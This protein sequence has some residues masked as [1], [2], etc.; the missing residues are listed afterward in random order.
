MKELR[1][2]PKQEYS[3]ASYVVRVNSVYGAMNSL[4]ERSVAVCR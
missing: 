3:G 4:F 1:Q 2:S